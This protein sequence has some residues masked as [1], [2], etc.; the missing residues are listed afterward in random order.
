MLT[1]N[2]TTYELRDVYDYRKGLR[3]LRASVG[4]YVAYCKRG[5]RNWELFDDTNKKIKNCQSKNKSNV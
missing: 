3:R 1:H 4:H 2:N 5:P